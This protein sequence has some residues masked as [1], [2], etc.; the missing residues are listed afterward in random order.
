[1]SP[2][3]NASIYEHYPSLE[4]Y[5]IAEPLQVLCIIQIARNQ[6]QIF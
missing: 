6:A 1:L 4:I 5:F 2:L 3:I